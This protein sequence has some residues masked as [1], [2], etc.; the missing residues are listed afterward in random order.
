MPIASVY[1]KCFVPPCVEQYSCKSVLFF[2]LAAYKQVW[3]IGAVVSALVHL[4][5][6]SW[7]RIPLGALPHQFTQLYK[8]VPGRTETMCIVLVV[9]CIKA[10]KQYTPQGAGKEKNWN[11]PEC[12]GM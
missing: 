4:T 5:P 3:R 11:D 12:S 9:R 10:A 1:C 8:W 7:V 2:V 6:R